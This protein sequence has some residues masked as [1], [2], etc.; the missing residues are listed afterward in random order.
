MKSIL[1]FILHILTQP[2]ILLPLIPF[3]PLLLQNKSPSPITSPTIKT[4]LPFLILTPRP[5]LL[6]KSLQPFPKIFQHP[7]PLQPILPNNQA[8]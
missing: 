2:P 3:I 5:Q 8:I 1:H 7:F 4:I 6:S